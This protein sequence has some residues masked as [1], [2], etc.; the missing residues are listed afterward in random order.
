[1]EKKTS[2]NLQIIEIH[3][4]RRGFLKSW[5]KLTKKNSQNM[6][7]ANDDVANSKR[8]DKIFYTGWG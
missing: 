3:T 2:E 4:S 6:F 1:M 5:K 8:N 7:T